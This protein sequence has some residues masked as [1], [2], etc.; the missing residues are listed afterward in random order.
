MAVCLG[1]DSSDGVASLANDVAVVGVA[2][3][4]LHGDPCVGAGVQHLAHHFLCPHDAL[5]HSAA[6]TDVGVLLALGSY[7]QSK[8]G[9]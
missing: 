7:L 3:I 5:L 4:L 9:P 2:H 8:D 6:H 1:H